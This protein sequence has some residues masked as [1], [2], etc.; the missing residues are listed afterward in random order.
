MDRHMDNET[1]A[2]RPAEQHDPRLVVVSSEPF[3]AET[4]LAENIGLLTPNPLFYVRSHFPVPQL[5]AANWRLAVEGEVEH[6]LQ[7]SYDDLRRLPSR[8]LLV[9][10]ECAG[11]GRID[12]QPP[13]EGEPWNYG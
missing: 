4:A 11:N 1:A 6:P 12:L 2:T 5:S 7:V 13:A 3:N 9:T 8:S 10:L